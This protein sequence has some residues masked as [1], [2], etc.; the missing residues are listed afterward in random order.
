MDLKLIYAKRAYEAL[1]KGAARQELAYVAGAWRSRDG[2]AFEDADEGIQNVWVQVAQAAREP[3]EAE[4][5]N[6]DGRSMLALVRTKLR[7]HEGTIKLAEMGAN[8]LNDRRIWAQRKDEPEVNIPLALLGTIILTLQ[9]IGWMSALTE[10][11]KTAA[12]DLPCGCRGIVRPNT[13][14]NGCYI[15]KVTD[16]CEHHHEHWYRGHRLPEGYLER[17]VDQQRADELYGMLNRVLHGEPEIE[18]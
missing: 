4:L 3:A 7:S 8:Y 13:D 12:Q 5:T 6:N 1:M 16:Y 17:K 14:G 9:K 15:A 10:Y 18:S 11:D 2:L